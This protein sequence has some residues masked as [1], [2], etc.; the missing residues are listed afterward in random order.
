MWFRRS[1]DDFGP[2]DWSDDLEPLFPTTH[3]EPWRATSEEVFL[4]PLAFVDSFIDHRDL[5]QKKRLDHDGIAQLAASIDEHGLF[6][7]GQIIFDANGKLRYHD[8]YHRY[9]AVESLGYFDSIPV[10]VKESQTVRGYGRPI[11]ENTL[12]V[13]KL[14]TVTADRKSTTRRALKPRRKS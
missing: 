6:K 8:G 2:F 9:A 7:P 11:N 13:L 4:L 10:T 5:N 3:P 1:L 12:T 14:F